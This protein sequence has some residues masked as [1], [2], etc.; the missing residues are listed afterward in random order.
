MSADPSVAEHAARL[1]ERADE[2]ALC[3]DFD[4]TLSPI[5]DDPQTARPLPGTV[6]LLGQL[7]ARFADVASSRAARPPTWP[8]MPAAPGVR[9]LR[10]A[11]IRRR[12]RARRRGA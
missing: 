2:V 6:E 9:Y 11:R 3:L 4:G 10:P 5:V 7:V 8:S 1:A 12:G